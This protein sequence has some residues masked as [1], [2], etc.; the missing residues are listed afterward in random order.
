MTVLTPGIRR[1]GLEEGESGATVGY[2]VS[3]R[4][5]WVIH[6]DPVLLMMMMNQK[7][8]DEGVRE[9][10]EKKKKKIQ[11]ERK[12]IWTLCSPYAWM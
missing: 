9:I 11:K 4:P 10:K 12:V 2:T 5:T 7:D 1:P 6:K 3:S 8:K